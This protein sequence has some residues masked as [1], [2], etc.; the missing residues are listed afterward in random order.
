M[1]G[2][3]T[4]FVI[5][6]SAGSA[7][8]FQGQGDVYKRQDEKPILVKMLKKLMITVATATTPKSSGDNMRASTAVTIKEINI[9]EYLAIAVQKTPEKIC[10]FILA[11]TL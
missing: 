4:L 11:I 9:P 6:N 10:C 1:Q 2:Y 3:T 5:S 7:R 8:T